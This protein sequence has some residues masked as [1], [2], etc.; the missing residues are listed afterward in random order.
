MSVWNRADY[1]AASASLWRAFIQT[2]QGKSTGQTIPSDNFNLIYV[3]VLR[4]SLDHALVS[5]GYYISHIYT[6]WKKYSIHC[7]HPNM[8]T[9]GNDNTILHCHMLKMHN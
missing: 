5:G 6:S 1:L 8:G 3:R 7:V 4:Y 2:I 9:R